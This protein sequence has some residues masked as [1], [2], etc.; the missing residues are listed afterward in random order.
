MVKILLISLII[1]TLLNFGFTDVSYPKKTKSIL[2]LYEGKTRLGENYPVLE[3][4]EKYLRHFDVSIESRYIEEI[5]STVSSYDYIF[6]LGLQDRRLTV[7]LLRNISKAKK[8]VW[9]EANVKQYAYYSGWK[10]FEDYGYKTGY[11]S[12]LYKG[13]SISFDLES[14]VYI[15]YP[16]DRK[17]LAFIYNYTEK[18]PLVWEKRNF[19]FF[20]RLDFRDNSFLV[21]FDL[22]HDILKEDHKDDR[23]ILLL[24]DE[25]T[26]LTSAE[27]LR[28]LLLSHC[29]EDISINLVVYPKVKQFRNIHYIGEN[30]ALI[31]VLKLVEEHNGAIILGSYSIRGDIDTSIKEGLLIL[32]R[33]EIFPIAFKLP[34]SSIETYSKASKSF[35]LLVYEGLLSI[36]SP[37]VV[38]YP[39]NMN[40]YSLS[41]PV[42]YNYL[43]KR[44]LEF[45]VLRDAI[46]GI[47]FP[48][49]ASTDKLRELISDIR[50]LGYRFLE[51]RNEPF[52]VESEY[53]KVVNING[54]K[55]VNNNIPPLEETFLQKV[56]ETFISYLRLILIVAISLFALII[57]Y[58]IRGKRK[59]YETGDKI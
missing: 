21:F 14:P 38:A 46:I 7:D 59:L 58:L 5:P 43:L 34:D 11:G 45:R 36:N 18:T 48:S 50:T 4:L 55:L 26:P 10:D 31:E 6:Y 2:I 39:I 24:L 35:K 12:I 23:K 32:G 15:A 17:D 51:L 33:L 16:R 19:W 53:V 27:K 8:L 22:L 54:K 49:Y 25:V 20:G 40:G 3:L 37:K 52:R 13:E 56:F 1:L 44:A 29:C 28:K 42:G 57:F 30:K 41:D 9:I 47:T